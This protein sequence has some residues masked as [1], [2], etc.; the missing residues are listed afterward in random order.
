MGLRDAYRTL[1]PE[2]SSIRTALAA[3]D[4]ICFC[5]SKP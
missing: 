4:L 1:L 5:L 3:P 2:P